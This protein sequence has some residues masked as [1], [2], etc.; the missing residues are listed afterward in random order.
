MENAMVT[1][2]MT[3]EKKAR[4]ARILR[5]EGLNASQAINI[6][7]DRIIEHGD[8]RFLSEGAGAPC[9]QDWERAARFVDSLSEKRSSRF[10]GMTKAEVKAERLR[11]RG[12]M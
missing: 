8:A 5:R 11:A 2:R 6:L 9:P 1:G 4:G 3:E 12:L 7:Y 10:D